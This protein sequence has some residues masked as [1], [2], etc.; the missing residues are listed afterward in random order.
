[1]TIK[2]REFLAFLGI[3]AGTVTL[4]P[5]A[6]FPA[7]EKSIAATIP[8]TL[9]KEL[10]NPN[11]FSIQLP[12]PLD[13]DNLTADEQKSAYSTYEVVD[14]LVLPS[15]FTY[16]VIAAWGD[17][18][19]DSRFG[20]NNDYLSL[21]ETAPNEGLLTVNFEYI[22]S[23]TWLQTFSKVIGQSLPLEIKEIPTGYEEEIQAFEL[24]ENDP[25]K[26][27][28]KATC[29]QAL[30]DLGI[31]VI[32]IRRNS[33]GQWERTYAKTDRRI[34]GISGLKDGRYLKATG[35]AVAVFTKTNKQGYDDQLGEKI[36][37]TFQ[38]CAGGTTP[39][40]TVFSAEENFQD[41]VPEAV[42]ADGSSLKPSQTPF[43]IIVSKTGGKNEVNI[44]GWANVFGL[45]GNKYGWMVEIDPANP[46]DY[47]TKHTWLGRYR[48]EAVAFHTVADKPLAVYSGCDRR[49]GHLY[50]FVSKANIKDPKDKSNSRLMEDGMLYGAK[51]NPDGTGRW[52]ALRPDTPVDPVLPSQVQGKEGQGIVGLPNPKR[53]EGGIIKISRDEDITSYKQ[54]FKT[55]SDLYPGNPSEKQGAILIDA[56]YAANAAGV[57]CTARPEDTEMSPDGTLYMTYTSGTPDSS[58]GPDPQIFK[59]PNGETAYEFGWIM[60]LKE[61]NNDPAA[62]TFRW[63]LFSTGG[64]PAKG[65]L[66]F[67]NPDNLKL[68][69][70]GNLWMVTD[71]TTLTMNKA[72]PERVIEGKAVSQTELVGLFGNNSA[73]F[74]PTS[75][76]NAGN[77]YPFAIGPME[78]EMTGPTFTSDQKTLLISIQHP[79][80][81]GGIRENMQ[82]ETRNFLIQ[83]TNGQEFTQKRTVPIGSNWPSKKPND[84]PRPAIVAIRRLNQETIA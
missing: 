41:Q 76:K 25:L 11:L 45:A 82:S 56:H 36:I 27:Q 62:M 21:L 7:T 6:K 2:R 71:M 39:W 33:N 52:I 72:I 31:G 5:L 59:G 77:A 15:G 22:S 74:I 23:N 32:S 48:H 53:T 12:I 49:G 14:D 64:E 57:T 29:E 16:D 18:V 63:K 30:I 24:P 37:G 38:N 58:G 75:G 4:N 1:M 28:V 84:P 34:T 3:S 10:S 61:D 47:G 78:T 40:G 13:I 43:K 69:N 67:S 9:A 79:G 19:G 70:K 46:N 8:N 80:E 51:F 68:D 83:T 20:Y 73:W 81:A 66:G 55:L 65:G 42:M 35:P 17:P 60:S 54:Q 26:T 50:K 44:T